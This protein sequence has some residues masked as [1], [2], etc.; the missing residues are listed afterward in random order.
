LIEAARAIV[1]YDEL[2]DE[3]RIKTSR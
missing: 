1:K 2:V 3:P